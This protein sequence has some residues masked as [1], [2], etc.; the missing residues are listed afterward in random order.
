MGKRVARMERRGRFAVHRPLVHRVIHRE[1]T[2][3]RV[4]EGVADA[5]HEVAGDVGVDEAGA[6][7]PLELVEHQHLVEPPEQQHDGDGA[8]P[9]GVAE[10]LHPLVGQ[11]EV[12]HPGADDPGAGP[13]HG[14]GQP[15]RPVRR[16]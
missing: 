13:D 11:A 16:G 8:R 9:H 10:P 14:A 12:D 2:G 5:L 1:R 7:E 15:T 4:V 6:A 3:R